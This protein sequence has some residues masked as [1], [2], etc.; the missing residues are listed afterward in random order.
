MTGARPDVSEGCAGL[1][2]PALPAGRD[3]YER[4]IAAW[5]D[6]TTDGAYRHTVQ[7]REPGA[8]VEVT[9]DAWPSPTYGIRTVRGR[10]LAGRVD[11]AVLDGLATLDGGALAAGL[12]R[13]VREATGNGAGAGLALDAVIEAARLARQVAHLPRARV[14]EAFAAGIVERWGLDVAGWAD[15]PGSCFAYQPSTAALLAARP[16]V[17]PMTPDLY[18]PRPGQPRVFVRRRVATLERA[19]AGLRLAH[20]LDDDIHHFDLRLEADLA[21]GRIAR[22]ECAT[23]RLPYG[24]VCGE[25]QARLG[26][27]VGETIDA[28]LPRRIQGLLGGATG[29]AQLYDLVADLL[30]LALPPRGA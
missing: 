1:V 6:S 7:V 17:S 8:A 26:S 4:V 14:A 18:C 24:S 3:R 16:V 23:P 21:S 19:G 29:C 9:V 13:R 10:A 30:K 11:P 27:L 2:P 20:L 28:G 25:P 12:G 5:C 22:A 15:L